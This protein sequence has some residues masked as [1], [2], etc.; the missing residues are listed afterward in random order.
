VRQ[1][2]DADGDGVI[3][4]GEL[5]GVTSRHN[6]WGFVYG[7]ESGPVQNTNNIYYWI[8]GSSNQFS[9]SGFVCSSC[10]DPHAGGKT[11]GSVSWT[12]PGSSYP[13]IITDA[14][15]GNPRL[16]RLSIF[17]KTVDTLIF[18]MAT[19]GAFTYQGVSSGVYRVTEYVYGS[20]SWCGACHNR[21]DTSTA[22]ERIAG[23]GHAAQYL[24]M[25]RHPMDVHAVLPGGAD[26]TVATGT[27]LEVWTTGHGGG[28]SD[29]VA[30]LTC[31]RAHS[32]T[33][34]VAGWAAS[35]PRDAADPATGKAQ[36]DTSALL[37]MD[38]RGTC[39]NC[40]G[41]GKYNSWSD[42]RVRCADCHPDT[43]RN[44]N[45]SGGVYCTF[46]HR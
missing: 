45:G 23:E 40:H 42:P 41:A 36:G 43:D 22:G 31:H 9:G 39:H 24:G 27:P 1:F 3:D 17:G 19:V 2:V 15:K 35:W 29:K 21:F 11:P 6:V 32:T 26:G 18:R 37:R 10:H 5:K 34:V 12:P 7:D 13:S 20:A 16:L 8:P 46:C 4:S 44:H 25:W 38:N 14:V 30:C 28:L 33:A